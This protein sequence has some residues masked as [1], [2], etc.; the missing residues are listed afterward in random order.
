MN[1]LFH[2]LVLCSALT[3]QTLS[4]SS[5]ALATTSPGAAVNGTIPAAAMA[6]H[7]VYQD[8]SLSPDG[9]KLAI[10]VVQ[11]DLGSIIILD[12]T[13]FKPVATIK[14]EGRYEPSDAWWVNNERIVTKVVESS[15][16]RE[17]SAYYGELYAVNYDGSDGKIIYGYRAGGSETGSRLNRRQNTRGWADF[18]DVLPEDD[19]NVLISSTLMSSDGS[20]K[21]SVH[22]L[23]VYTG[24]MSNVLTRSPLP[25]ASFTTDQ[26]GRIRALIGAGADSYSDVYLRDLET[27]EWN[28]ASNELLGESFSPLFIDEAGKYLYVLDEGDDDKN[29]LY[30]MNLTDHSVKHVFTDK[31]VDITNVTF[32]SDGRSAYALRLDD[33]RPEYVVFSSKGVEAELYKQ[34]IQSFP[35]NAVSILSRSEDASKWIVYVN[36]D[37]SPG[38]YYLFDKSNNRLQFLFK[39]LDHIPSELMSESQPIEFAASD[40]KTIHGYL[41]Y[42]VSLKENETA[43]LVVL[44]HGGPHGIRDFWLFDRDTQFLASH[45][46]AVLRVNYRGSGGYGDDYLFSGYEHWGDRIQQDIIDGAKWASKQDGIAGER[47][48]I[49]GAS[50]GAYSAVMSATIAPEMFDCVIANAGVYDLNLMFDEGDIPKMLYGKNRLRDFLGDDPTLLKAFSPINHIDKLAAPILIGHGKKDERT[51]FVHAELL[52]DALEQRNLPYVWFIRA[53]ESHGFFDEKNREEWYNE[54]AKFLKSNL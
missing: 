9:T 52:R 6:K 45:G 28:L 7:Y 47:V 15:L 8:A 32:S 37:I 26:Q 22:R 14:F 18:I 11:G 39:N 34:L 2:A 36:S 31:T 12:L 3:A 46:Y 17:Q 49:M 1:R 4:L 51:P 50:F 30:K 23:N 25:Q 21:P 13:T 5:Y 44:V 20:S 24:Q 16:D 42:P 19:K 48:C 40:G 54:V 33:G 35:G 29:G 41:T 38:T 10:N 43:P 27:N 53:T